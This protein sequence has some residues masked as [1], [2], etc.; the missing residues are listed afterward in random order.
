MLGTNMSL[1]WT[2]WQDTSLTVRHHDFKCGNLPNVIRTGEKSRNVVV[3]IIEAFRADALSPHITPNIFAIAQ[4]GTSYPNAYAASSESSYSNVAINSGLYPL[5]KPWRDTFLEGPPGPLVYDVLSSQGYKTAYLSP[6]DERWQNVDRILKSSNLNVFFEASNL[7]TEQRKELLLRS[8]FKELILEKDAELDATMVTA[9]MKWLQKDVVNQPFFARLF[10]NASHF[11]YPPVPPSLTLHPNTELSPEE[12]RSLSYFSYPDY[13][14]PK[15]KRRYENSLFFIDYLIGSL[16]DFLRSKNSEL[17]ETI[18][19]ITGDHGELFKEH[20][21]VV[22]GGTL[23]DEVIRVPLV[24]SNYGKYT[25]AAVSHVD[26][27]PTVLELAGLHWPRQGNSLLRELPSR[28]IFSSIQGL[29][30]SDAAIVGEEKFIRDYL[31]SAADEV[32][33]DKGSEDDIGQ[34]ILTT[35]RQRQFYFYESKLNKTCLPPTYEV[36]FDLLVRSD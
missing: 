23:H 22:H 33:K 24:I 25:E 4:E 15:M 9:L 31:G 3:V 12:F 7:P 35:F 13:L 30:D 36:N 27:Y 5:R 16:R 8:P 32:L 17:G 18:M 19:I 21:E 29:K 1:L 26:I 28:A 20:G 10:F 6:H 14:V 34:S 11:P 2:D